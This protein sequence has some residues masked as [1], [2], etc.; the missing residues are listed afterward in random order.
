MGLKSDM[1]AAGSRE[2]LGGVWVDRDQQPT[3]LA[4]SLK[5]HQTMGAARVAGG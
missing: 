3:S 2:L 5:S 1:A 4:C